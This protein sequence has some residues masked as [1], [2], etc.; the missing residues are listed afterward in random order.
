VSTVCCLIFYISLKGYLYHTCAEGQ[1]GKSKGALD[2]F[3]CQCT[4]TTSSKTRS[5]TQG[6]ILSVTVASAFIF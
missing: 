3:A 6:L 1:C 4:Y 5:A 2:S